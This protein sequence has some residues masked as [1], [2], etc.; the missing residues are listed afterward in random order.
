MPDTSDPREDV[1]EIIPWEGVGK[2]GHDN[3]YF[4]TGK[5]KSRAK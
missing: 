3:N 5:K 4:L 1:G 2:D